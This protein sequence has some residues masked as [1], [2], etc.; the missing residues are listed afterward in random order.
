M[1]DD[2][3]WQNRQHQSLLPFNNL[4]SLSPLKVLQQKL[5]PFR[6]VTKGNRADFKEEKSEVRMASDGIHE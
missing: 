5:S 1:R 4:L 3:F 6:A 2:W